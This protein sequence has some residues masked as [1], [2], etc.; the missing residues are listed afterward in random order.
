[1][2]KYFG[3]DGVRGR[4]GD[5]PITP[6][7]VMQLAWAAGRVLGR[8]APGGS[9]L[10]GKDTRVSGYLLESALE[11]G[12]SAA[13]M[14]V[15]LLGPMP[16]PAVAYLARSVQACAGVVVSASHNSF[17]DNGIKFFATDGSKLPD[18]V[19]C[20]IESEMDKPLACVPPARLGKAVRFTYAAN[21]YVEFCKSGMASG[22]PLQGLCVVVDSANGAAYQIAPR[23]FA[24]LGARVIAIADQPDGF[25]INAGCGSTHPQLMQQMVREQGADL[26]IAL[27]GDGDRVILADARGELVDGDAI[28]YVLAQARRRRGEAGGVVGT[29]MSNLGLEQACAR[30]GVPFRRAAVG[31]RYVLALMQ[32]TGWRLGGEASGH[33]ISLDH[34]TTG[35]GI[36]AALQVLRAMVETGR[37]L[38][39]LTQGMAVFPQKMINVRLSDT[40]ARGGLKIEDCMPVQEALRAARTELAERGRVVLRASGTEPV[41]RVM[42]EADDRALVD[43]ISDELAAVVAAQG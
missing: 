35:D 12:L 15:S 31:D 30:L 19:E 4:M 38:A 26:G 17:E 10:I 18:D 41:V 37:P 40:R 11:A 16:T 25:N 14:N 1:M 34:A 2:R 24:E 32:Q 9:V 28:L 7:T 42:V 27:D 39:E 3:T 6:H 33:I 22:S 36:V 13:G 23:V 8:G 29:L 20:G 21:R 5:E 43:R